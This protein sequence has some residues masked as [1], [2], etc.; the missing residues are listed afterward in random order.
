MLGL[1]ALAEDNLDHAG[2]ANGAAAGESEHDGDA[3]SSSASAKEDSNSGEA[4][5]T[6]SSGKDE[7]S[8]AVGS[9]NQGESESAPDGDSSEG[10]A[11]SGEEA[12]GGGKGGGG[13]KEDEV[14][15]QK[16]VDP[17]ENCPKHEGGNGGGGNGGGGNGGGGNGGGAVGGRTV[18][19]GEPVLGITVSRGVGGQAL[20]VTGAEITPLLVLALGLMLAGATIVL[21]TRKAAA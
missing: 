2:E 9:A 1:P 10:I 20:A 18:T 13:Q 6:Q 19:R 17:A 12:T 8:E 15:G 3:D 14:G 16:D 21:A 5:T 7:S 11:T 4:D